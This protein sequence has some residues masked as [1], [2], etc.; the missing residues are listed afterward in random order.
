MTWL[1]EN[2]GTVLVVIGLGMLVAE[3]AVF[4]FSVFILFFVG[5]GCLLAGALIGLGFL[6]ASVT[7]AMVLVAVFSGL[8]A[9]TLWKP[10]KDMQNSGG[11]REVSNDLV[12]HSFLLRHA[13]SPTH[14]T[15]YR[16]SG[17]DWKVK[18]DMPLMAGTQV[19][20]VRVDV[21]ELTVVAV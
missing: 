4:G 12:G 17:I 19:R 10:L 21:G 18:A 3:V 11:A 6:P 15:T 1:S 20:V 8:F 2:L 13:V 16:Y 5:L 9:Y 14:A 7:L